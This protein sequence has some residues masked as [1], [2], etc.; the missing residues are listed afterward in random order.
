MYPKM[1]S[2]CKRNEMYLRMIFESYSFLLRK[3]RIV[4]LIN[5]LK[6]RKFVHFLK[7][8]NFLLPRPK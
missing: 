2:F 8:A 7:K 1:Y 6:L 4:T 5:H 3:L